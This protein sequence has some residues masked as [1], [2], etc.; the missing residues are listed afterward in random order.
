MSAVTTTSVTDRTPALRGLAAL[1]GVLNC[2]A[3]GAV[4]AFPAVVVLGLP[5]IVAALTWRARPRTAA[6]LAGLPAAVVT[7]WWAAYYSAN[8]FGTTSVAQEV[9]FLPA[10]PVAAALLVTVAATAL[11][12]GFRRGDTR[13]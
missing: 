13:S 11:R 6:V 7:V 2:L 3:W 8:G 9:W 10:G 1:S 12:N 5:P 4:G